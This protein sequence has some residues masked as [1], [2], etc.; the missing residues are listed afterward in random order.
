MYSEHL[1]MDATGLTRGGSTMPHRRRKAGPGNCPRIGDCRRDCPQAHQQHL[2]QDSCHKSSGCNQVLTQGVPRLH[3]GEVPQASN[4]DDD[5]G[6]AL[7][8]QFRQSDPASLGLEQ[9]KNHPG[10][11]GKLGMTN[12]PSVE[13][14]RESVLSFRYRK[15]VYAF[16]AALQVFWSRPSEQP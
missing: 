10:H 8:V 5:V 12:I 16:K 14:P 6:V 15:P 3:G 9:R 1:N 13:S 7:G 2:L 4:G 11:L